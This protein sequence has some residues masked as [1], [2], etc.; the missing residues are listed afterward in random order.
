M[1]MGRLFVS[2]LLVFLLIW[3][4]DT[5][6]EGNLKDKLLESKEKITQ[7]V[8]NYNIPIQQDPLILKCIQSFNSCEQIATKKY[9]WS[10]SILE[11][12]EF[13]DIQEAEEFYNTWSGLFEFGSYFSEYDLPYVLI[14]VKMKGALTQLP[15]VIVCEDGELTPAA[16]SK[17]MCGKL[18]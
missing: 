18:I 15:T 7:K 1:K 17:L 13:D 16:K 9:D 12:E 8:D 6:V 14:A 3:F 11:I 5:K 10:L 4:V 2:I